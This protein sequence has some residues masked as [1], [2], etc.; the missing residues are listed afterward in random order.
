MHFIIVRQF[1]WVLR[2]K[3]SLTKTFY[4]QKVSFSQRS[5]TSQKNWSFLFS[6][7]LNTIK[8]IT[9]KSYTIY[10]NQYYLLIKQL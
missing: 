7:R 9:E 3:K 4:S 1:I 6:W 8:V 5:F 2:S 10:P